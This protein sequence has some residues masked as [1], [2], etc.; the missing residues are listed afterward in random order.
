MFSLNPFAGPFISDDSLLHALVPLNPEDSL[1]NVLLN[2][3]LFP[4]TH[5]P[6]LPFDEDKGCGILIATFTTDD[7]L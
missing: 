2:P 5:E 7:P 4:I 3:D 1:I 6:P